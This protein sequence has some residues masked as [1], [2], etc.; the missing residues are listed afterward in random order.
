LLASSSFHEFANER[1]VTHAFL[2]P[3]VATLQDSKFVY[4][5]NKFPA[6]GELFSHLAVAGFFSEEVLISENLVSLPCF[7]ALLCC[8]CS[9]CFQVARFYVASMVS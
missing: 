3:I 5:L 9:T 6:G 4:I 7:L 1:Q 2:N 8:C